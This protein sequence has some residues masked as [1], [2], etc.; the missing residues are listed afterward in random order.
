MFIKS[1][2]L[3]VLVLLLV[4][5]TAT[6]QMGALDLTLTPSLGV[7]GVYAIVAPNDVVTLAVG[8]DRLN[9]EKALPAKIQVYASPI[10]DVKGALN[11]ETAVLLAQGSVA[12]GADFAVTFQI[13]EGL[14]FTNWSFQAV[15]FY[16]GGSIATSKVLT[17]IINSELAAPPQ[18]MNPVEPPDDARPPEDK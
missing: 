9:A 7:P 6:A 14:D 11:L 2:A 5:A 12:A 8:Q 18:K 16:K 17:V 3:S 13:S 4:S 1:T 10:D 15:A